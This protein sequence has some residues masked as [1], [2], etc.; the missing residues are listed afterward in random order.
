MH[1]YD[2]KNIKK[3]DVIIIGAGPSGC[4]CAH[5]LI[6]SNKKILLIDKHNFPRHK[7]CAGGITIKALNQLPIDISHLIQH[8]SYDMIFEFDEK[9]KINLNNQDGS[10][11]MVIR[12]DF[13]KFFFDETIKLGIEFL[14]IK[15]IINITRI[16]EN[17]FLNLDGIKF[18]C[19]YLIGADGA[20]STVRKMTTSLSYKTPVYAFEGI[21]DKNEFNKDI[22]TEFVFNNRGYGWIFPKKNHLNVGIGNLINRENDS[23]PRKKDLFDFVEK[24]LKTKN[25]TN[26]TGF[27]IGTE[28]DN[29]FS[30]QNIF[31]VGDAA[32]LSESLL[33]EGIYNALIS[34]KYAA[35]SILQAEKDSNHDAKY[36]YNLFLERLTKELKLYRKGSKLLY[37]YPKL[38]YLL[39][40]FG[41]GKK[42]MDGYS[43]GKTLTEII[44]KSKLLPNF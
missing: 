5:E 11:V 17:I 10:C 42:F 28:G 25:I 40:K 1:H 3:F 6:K 37:N 7:P 2:T 26:I 29:Y 39:M 9:R 30:T 16:G 24:R 13:D 21:V 38:T 41:L 27:P 22:N 12:E 32:G 43:Q 33:G 8:Q 44:K 34:G 18:Q 20:N 23:K 15:K 14:K 36:F 19:N 31:L 4:A 35:K